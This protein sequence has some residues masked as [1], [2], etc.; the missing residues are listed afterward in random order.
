M[1]CTLA[2]AL[3]GR[4]TPSMTITDAL[5]A[6]RVVV[7]LTVL[8]WP[9]LQEETRD[10]PLCLGLFSRKYIKTKRQEVQ[11]QQW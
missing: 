2:N 11:Q 6:F 8:P 4:I 5:K 1:A 7:E 3:F 9:P 10:L